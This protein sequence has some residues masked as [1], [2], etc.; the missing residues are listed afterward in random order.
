M[1]SQQNKISGVA[2][3]LRSRWAQGYHQADAKYCSD[4]GLQTTS[5]KRPPVSASL[6][7]RPP[8][9]WSGAGGRG[10][11][12]ARP[13]AQPGDWNAPR[14]WGAQSAGAAGWVAAASSSGRFGSSIAAGA[15]RWVHQGGPERALASGPLLSDL[16]QSLKT[17]ESGKG[18]RDKA[19]VSNAGA[20]GSPYC[21]ATGVSD[22]GGAKALAVKLVALENRGHLDSN[23]SS[24][25]H[26]QVTSYSS[27]CPSVAQA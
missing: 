12:A 10:P 22:G 14:L 20:R 27:V 13:G 9:G 5:P 8:R 2:S 1:T 26:G 16:C 21:A 25:T 3:H 18:G 17:G 11:G 4:L 6:Q 23:P 7:P 19:G 15:D 24:I